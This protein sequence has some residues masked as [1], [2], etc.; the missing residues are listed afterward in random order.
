MDDFLCLEA[1]SRSGETAGNFAARLSLMWTA[2]LR[3]QPDDFEGVYAEATDFERRGDRA[4]RQYLLVPGVVD[5]V[6][7]RL[8]AAGIDH[9]PVDPADGYSKYEAV[10]PEWMQIEH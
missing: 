4:A 8:A 1:I 7:A 3:E 9:E 2:V 6:L 10:A 5:A